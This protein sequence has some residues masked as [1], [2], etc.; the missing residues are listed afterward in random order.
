DEEARQVSTLVLEGL[1]QVDREGPF[2]RGHGLDAGVDGHD[3]I[4]AIVVDGRVRGREGG[5]G[6]QGA[7]RFH[8]LD[9]DAQVLDGG[10]YGGIGLAAGNVPVVGAVED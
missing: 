1:V 10:A 7:F 2:L 9:D 3:P 6:R 8:A 5:D 4:V